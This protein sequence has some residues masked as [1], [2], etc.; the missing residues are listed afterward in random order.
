MIITAP[1]TFIEKTARTNSSIYGVQ[2]ARRLKFFNQ[3]Y[4]RGRR[5]TLKPKT[6]ILQLKNIQIT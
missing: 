1:F 2:K 6:S 3:Q 4:A 5:A